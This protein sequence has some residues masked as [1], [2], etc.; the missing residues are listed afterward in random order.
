MRSYLAKLNVLVRQYPLMAHAVLV[1][2]IAITFWQVSDS[3]EKAREANNGTLGTIIAV[4]VDNCKNDLI[5]RKQYKLRGDAEKQLLDLFVNLAKAQVRMLPPD[6]P[7]RQV[8]EDFIKQFSPLTARIQLIPVPNC[9]LV[10]KHLHDAIGPEVPIPSLPTPPSTTK[11]AN[12][13]PRDK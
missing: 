8:S 5:F 13:V 2:G 11:S 1:L 9:N 7:Q 4:Q 10:E 12:N 3:R 6:D